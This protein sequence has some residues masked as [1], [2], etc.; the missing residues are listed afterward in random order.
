[1]PEGKALS[2]ESRKR[3]ALFALLGIAAVSSIATWVFSDG[4]LG[5]SL[6]LILGIIAQFVAIIQWCK[7]DAEQRNFEF[8]IGDR[9][10]IVLLALIGLPNYFIKS[11]GFIKGLVST[12]Y[13]IL[14]WILMFFVSMITLLALSL[15]EDRLGVFRQLP[16]L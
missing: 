12:G 8:S 6:T 14:F 16:T 1:M 13:A 7:A 2:F 10:F 15:A 11:R 4:G 3:N 9:V 5:Y